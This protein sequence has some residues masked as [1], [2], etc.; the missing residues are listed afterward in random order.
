MTSPGK[1]LE[2]LLHEIGESQQEIAT[3]L[4]TSQAT[5]SRWLGME[6]LTRTLRKRMH[7]LEEVY[8]IN[9]DWVESGQGAPF[10]DQ[11]SKANP[12]RLSKAEL[13]QKISELERENETLKKEQIDN[14]KTIAQLGKQVLDIVEKYESLRDEM[15]KK[16]HYSQ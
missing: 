5:I 14:L 16:G 2:Q 6:T 8:N 12:A 11:L 9:L 10:L 15:I 3:K 7:K 4:D 13:L 1:R